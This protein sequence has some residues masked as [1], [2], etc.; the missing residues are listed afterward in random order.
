MHP[1]N[2][3]NNLIGQVVILRYIVFMFYKIN[4]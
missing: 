1:G 3:Q 2:M 4:I